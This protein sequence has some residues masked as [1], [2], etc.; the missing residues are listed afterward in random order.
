M[1]YK[2]IADYCELNNYTDYIT[3]FDI[4]SKE[5]ITEGKVRFNV[6]EGMVL[7]GLGMVSGVELID[8]LEA[9]MHP[10]VIRILRDTG[11]D[12]AD[13][14]SRGQLGLLL[15][16]NLITQTAYDWL[17]AQSQDVKPKWVGLK[18]GHV[19]NAIEWRD[20]GDI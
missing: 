8:A 13:S 11:V 10:A 3:A 20:A 1:D 12:V 6:T 19:Q 17:V 9:T 4:M 7:S 15:A 5:T 16:G 2:E 18:P 14:E